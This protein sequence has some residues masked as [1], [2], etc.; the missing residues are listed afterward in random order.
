MSNVSVRK[1]PR[2]TLSS[3]VAFL[4][5]LSL[6]GLSGCSEKAP[7]AQAIDFSGPTMGTSYS[8]KIKQ[9]PQ[10][11]AYDQVAQG[12]AGVLKRVND[13]MSTYQA[14]SELSRFNQSNATSAV[15]ASD[16]L[17]KVVAEAQRISKLS[18]GAFD[19]TV[20]PLVNLW[21]FGPDMSLDRVPSAAEIEQMQGRVGYKKLTADPAAGQLSK[22]RAELYVDLSA[23]AKGYGVDAVAEYLETLGIGDYLVEVGGELRARG[24]SHRGTPWRIAVEKP[25][26][27][28]RDIQ[29]VL[30]LRDTAIATSGDYRNYFEKDGVRYSH[31]INP[32]TGKPITHT[33]ASV[34]VLHPSA[35]T[36]DGL[37]T[38]L[39]VL[40]PKE[41]MAL[42]EREKLSAY[43]LIKTENGFEEQYTSAFMAYLQR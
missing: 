17:L 26:S 30:E 7:E 15:A 1:A 9:M 42:A 6:V 14:D 5:L 43:F 24:Q 16:E 33:L 35:M 23:I 2:W 37:S 13:V 19:V 25:V 36:A 41:G 39:M 31:T 18:D 10:G 28:S 29:K 4:L 22:T 32:K 11:I 38:L 12:I 21:G 3:A 8:V 40:G 20:G 27:G 34:S